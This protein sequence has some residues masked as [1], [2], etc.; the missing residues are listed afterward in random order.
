MLIWGGF[1]EN[2][3]RVKG[4]ESMAYV[5]DIII[6]AV[7]VLSA[8]LGHRR[9]L[10]KTVFKCLSLVIAIA[11][12][13]VFGSAAG[14]FIKSTPV[15]EKVETAVSASVDEHFDKAAS[16]GLDEAKK[17]QLEFEESVI[18][19]N[20]KRIG[21][22]SGDLYEKYESEMLDGKES[23]KEN[24][25]KKTSEWILSCLACA[26]GTLCVFLL[27]L[28][29]LKVLSKIAEA[30]FRLPFLKTVNKAGG[31]ILGFALGLV[32]AFAVCA[33]IEI[34]LPYI[35]K[36]PVIYMGMEENTVLYKFFLNLNPLLFLF[37]G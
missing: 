1:C 28:L 25:A 21:F 5:A 24:F 9:G 12:A 34:L 14:E 4:E 8:I 20:L 30:L 10:V 2:P 15:Y 17:A 22:D 3:A 27:S 26:L 13:Y 32:Y 31:A 18:G 33:V 19:K 37:F 35:P 16:E 29:L 11:A 6:V 7:I 36:N 23:L